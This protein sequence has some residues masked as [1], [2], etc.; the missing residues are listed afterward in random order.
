MRLFSLRLILSLIVAITLVSVLSVY[1][2]VRGERRSLRA[3]LE[4]R[5]AVLAD[6]LAGNVQP[7]L[8]NGS[9]ANLQQIVDRFSNREHLAG[10]AVFNQQLQLRAQSA[11]LSDRMPAAPAVATQAIATQQKQSAFLKISGRS[12]YVYAMPLNVEDSQHSGVL[13]IV[14]DATY[15]QD[16]TRRLWRETF[17]RVLVQVFLIVLITVL[18]VRWSIAAPI[19][20]VSQ[21]LRALRVG[22]A[23]ASALAIP[24]FD[25]LR[26]LAREM[27][28]LAQ[29]LTAARSAAEREAQLRQAGESSWTSERLSVH[30]RSKLGHSRLFVV[31]NREPY[32]HVRSGKSVQCVVPA[33]G[34]VTALEPILRACDGTWIAHGSGDADRETVDHNDRLAV[35]PDEPRYTLRRVWLTKEEEE[36][37]YY[38]F[39]NEGLWPLCH[40]AHTRPLF[41]GDDWEH[42][43]NTNIKFADAVLE[44]LRDTRDPVLLVQDYH[45]APLPRL[46]KKKRPDARVAIFWHIPWPNPEAFAI[47][48]WQRELLDGLLGADV[49][50]FH[51]QAH[52]SNFLQSVDRTLECRIDWEHSAINRQGHRTVIKPFPISVDFP[53]TR[54]LP[55]EPS[56]IYL[57]RAALLRELGVEGT[58]VGVGVDRVDYTKGIQERFLAI[59]RMLEKRP[60]YQGKFVFV[61]IGAPSR[62]HIKRYH[63]LLADV[64][65]EAER[66]NWRFQTSTWK[67]I[68][69]LKRHFSHKEITRY[70]RAADVCMVTALHDGMNLVAKEFIAARDDE[71]GVLV[72]SRFTGAARELLDSVLV[73]PYDIESTADAVCHALE[74]GPEERTARM[75]RLRKVVREQ[76]IYRWAGNLV[77]DLCEVRLEVPEE[78][79]AKGQA[80]TAAQ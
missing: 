68:V 57:D 71:Q 16:Q 33:S 69:F 42:Y 67:P 55:S 41:R 27:T 66:I 49:I 54:D 65:A 75:Q 63:D 21:W 31:S 28:S 38:G 59:E 2:Q 29:S 47:C 78:Y 44:E 60:T 34:L 11:G 58:F 77:T 1:K 36:G 45:F 74:M 51:I 26:P 48:P 7:H 50:G 70:Y 15:I 52:C 20:R 43:R 35:P 24:D 22:R 18:I 53:E 30:I 3:D 6:S 73:N 80:H 4:R 72:L 8:E 40:I 13:V 12:L 23:E 14:H 5:A 10:V 64:E 46:I 79:T 25:L 9:T 56:S 61:Q 37:Y 17:F 76:N 39:S 62:T 32:S 19:T